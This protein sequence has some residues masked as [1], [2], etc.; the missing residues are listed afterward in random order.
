MRAVFHTLGCKV[1]QYETEV[2]AGRL[3]EC[4][5]EIASSSRGT[6]DVV[7]VNSC[8]VTG[9]SDGKVR[10]LIRRCRREQPSAILVLTGCYPQAY[11]DIGSLVPEADIILGT[12]NR[13]ALPDYIDRF[14]LTGERIVEIAAH[15]RGEA[16]EDDP[17]AS[18][19]ERTRAFVKIQDGCNRYC[20]YC[21]IPTAR[22]PLRSRPLDSVREQ[23]RRLSD[24]GYREIVLTGINLSAYGEESGGGHTLFDA[25]EAACSAEGVERVR[26]G[27]LE[28]DKITPD[29]VRRLAALP[30]LCPQFHLSL[31]SGCDE[32]LRRM[33]RHYTAARYHTIADALREAFPGCAITTDIMVGFPGETAEEFEA[34][35]QFAR[36][37]AF[38]KAHV[39]I[40]SPREGTRAAK[41]PDQIP[42]HTAEQRS[43]RMIEVTGQTRAAFL[44]Q[45]LGKTFPVLFEQRHPDG[46]FTGYTPDY[47]PVRVE[48]SGPLT[49]HT[50]PVRITAA[51]EDSCTGQLCNTIKG[52]A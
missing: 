15:E 32:T 49:G 37:V 44:Q 16:F 10:K 43:R 9:E 39:F 3:A 13:P 17:I 50:L 45:H 12:K 33:N 31:Q 2:M 29:A 18:F 46:F 38:A 41:M 52:D 47:T 42:R 7:V 51:G 22:G 27:S 24:A 14:R 8:T 21:I 35:L 36:E 30:K 11:P 5:Y 48:S 40:Y 28:P 25:I 20:S 19:Q 4:G 1:N 26:L 34:S 23:C 6:A